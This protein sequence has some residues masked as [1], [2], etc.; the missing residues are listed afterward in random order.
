MSK[1]AFAVHS[2][3]EITKGKG[4]DSDIRIL[5]SCSSADKEQVINYFMQKL[6]QAKNEVRILE[7]AIK[8]VERN[9]E[10]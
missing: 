9:G 10:L 5:K 6:K 7:S 4:T 1:T 8:T 2:A 3:L